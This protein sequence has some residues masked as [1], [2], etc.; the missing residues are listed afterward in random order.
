VIVVSHHHHHHHHPHYHQHHHHHLTHAGTLKIN[1]GDQGNRVHVKAILTYTELA[2]DGAMPK[3]L[4]EAI[5]AL[6]RDSGVQVCML[7]CCQPDGCVF[8]SLYM[9]IGNGTHV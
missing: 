4:S 8:V 9:S 1:L 2:S 5:R 3:D 7:H 6:W